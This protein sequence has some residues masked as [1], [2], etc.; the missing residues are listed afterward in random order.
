MMLLNYIA[1]LKLLFALQDYL[2]LS[3][4]LILDSLVK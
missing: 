1:I 4:K 3:S 2:I